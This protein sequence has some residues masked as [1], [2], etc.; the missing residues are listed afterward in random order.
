MR[1]LDGLVA[2]EQHSSGC[3]IVLSEIT[4]R[5]GLFGWSAKINWSVSVYYDKMRN[6]VNTVGD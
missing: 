5:H 6:D 3:L 1:M 2:R 4:H